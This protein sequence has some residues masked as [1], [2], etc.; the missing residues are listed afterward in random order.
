MITADGI[1]EKAISLN[2]EDCGII[3]LQEMEGYAEK[4]N[5]RA[6]CFPENKQFLESFYR[7][8]E[9]KKH[10]EWAKSIVVCVRKYGKYF[11]PPSLDNIIAKYYLVDGRTDLLSP[12][13][14]DSVEFESYLNQLGLKTLTER[15]F[16]LTAARFAAV[17]AGLG[18]CRKNNFFYTNKSGSYVYLEVFLIDSA[19]ELKSNNEYK[20][21]P[22][23]CGKCIKACP[24]KSLCRPFAMNRDSCVSA[25]TT[26]SDW[27]P[28]DNFNTK[29]WLY[30]C[31]ACQDACPFNKDKWSNKEEFPNLNNLAKQIQ[32]KN[33]FDDNFLENVM[34]DKFWYIKKENLYR[35]K[36]NALRFMM[37]NYNKD[38]DVFINNACKD[39]TEKV[40]KASEFVKKAVC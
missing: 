38:Y 26:F 8:A 37:N 31:D 21:C 5:E 30:G 33:L 2:Y 29:Q 19:L 23:D 20:E 12:D 17:K 36:L 40:R 35:W 13:Y 32:I 15:K 11:I 27:Q 25:L 1:K 10:F 16:S 18:I 4:L 9:L 3:D 22:N 39:S 6:M 14:K 34:K 28:P 7:F 24:T